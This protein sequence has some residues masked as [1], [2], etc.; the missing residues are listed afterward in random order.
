MLLRY[1]PRSPPPSRRSWASPRRVRAA[2][3][4]RLRAS[5]GGRHSADGRRGARVSRPTA[6]IV[7]CAADVDHSR[8]AASG[9]FEARAGSPSRR[10]P[11]GRL[12]LTP[13][14]VADAAAAA[15]DC[16]RPAASP[17][18]A[19]LAALTLGCV[20]A[21]TVGAA[22]CARRGRDLLAAAAIAGASPEDTVRT[23]RVHGSARARIA[24]GS[25][26]PSRRPPSIA[27]FPARPDRA[28]ARGGCARGG[29]HRRACGCASG[30]RP[31]PRR[32]LRPL[33]RQ[34]TPPPPSPFAAN[35]APSAEP[36][37]V[38]R[39]AGAPRAGEPGVRAR[40]QFP[41]CAWGIEA[42]APAAAAVVLVPRASS[43]NGCCM[44]QSESTQKAKKPAPSGMLRDR[45]PST[46]SLRARKRAVASCRASERARAR[47][48]LPPPPPPRP[49]READEVAAAERAHATESASEPARAPSAG[50]AA[51]AG[52]ASRTHA[53]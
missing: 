47:A 17:R 10:W 8:L 30:P 15:A 9:C 35:C 16:E 6:A 7:L 38:Y 40:A 22:C 43:G 4:R 31:P 37:A 23:A 46:C 18:A 36:P 39:R 45:S 14:A 27:P 53:R 51:A 49:V 33:H 42:G 50:Q 21:V 1:S 48:T 52:S 2:R 28:D 24:N 12:S 41:G 11:P 20:A 25:A 34:W 19:P 3:A 13:P 32:L 26:A 44:A 29:R 5:R